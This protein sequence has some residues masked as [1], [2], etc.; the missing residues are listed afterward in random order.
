MVINLQQAAIQVQ[1]T[2]TVSHDSLTLVCNGCEV[3]QVFQLD[4]YDVGS[5]ISF[6]LVH[7]QTCA[8]KL[9][10]EVPLDELLNT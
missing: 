7:L 5:L 6:P 10:G 4:K 2:Y 3:K 9:I 1:V 8:T